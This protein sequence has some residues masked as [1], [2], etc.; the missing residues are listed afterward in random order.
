MKTPEQLQDAIDT[1]LDEGGSVPDGWLVIFL[2][3]PEGT[4]PQDAAPMFARMFK[5]LSEKRRLLVGGDQPVFRPRPHILHR[6]VTRNALEERYDYFFLPDEEV[7]ISGYWGLSFPVLFPREADIDRLIAAA[8][9]AGMELLP[10]E[11][12]E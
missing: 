10:P 11:G 12:E 9:A 7:V 5:A 1:L 2:A 6:I 3:P 8:T 4:S